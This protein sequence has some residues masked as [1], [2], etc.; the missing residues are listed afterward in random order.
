[1]PKR[2]T[3]APTS[4][5]VQ[6]LKRLDKELD[7]HFKILT[8]G[9]LPPI[10]YIDEDMNCAWNEFAMEPKRFNIIC[11]APGIGKTAFVHSL[12]F[13]AM[14]L[15][16]SLT[17]LE[18]NC[19]TPFE[20]IIERELSRQT[21]ISSDT[22]RLKGFN[23]SETGFT[24][25]QTERLI[26]AKEAMNEIANRYHFLGSDATFQDAIE[27]IKTHQI[28]VFIVDY[29]QI[30]DLG[31]NLSGMEKMVEFC[32]QCKMLK[33]KYD[34][35]II[36]IAAA[37]KESFDKK[38]TLASVRDSSEL[39]YIPD[40]CIVINRAE[41]DKSNLLEFRFEKR[42]NGDK[43]R[44][45]YFE[46]DGKSQTFFPC[47]VDGDKIAT[48]R[49]C[50]AL[51]DELFAGSQSEDQSHDEDDTF[52]GG[53]ETHSGGTGSEA[54]SDQNEDGQAEREVGTDQG[55]DTGTTQTEANDAPPTEE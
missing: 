55:G 3:K 8:N 42:R 31:G 6:K 40:D 15:N 34:L 4:A 5:P 43:A 30:M 2:T 20:T 37:T 54:P 29:V 19:D 26:V 9:Q 35:C 49:L 44:T 41:P 50:S 38:T 39:A 46:F 13:N 28:N 33:D 52:R 16:P 10:W 36:G 27:V 47:K 32:R 21:D 22:I 24:Q 11:A 48:N 25:R 45:V 53:S 7:K 17:V 18:I 12:V 51:T 23:E 14:R 1:M